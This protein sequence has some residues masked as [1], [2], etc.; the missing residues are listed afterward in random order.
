MS[1]LGVLMSKKAK[2]MD[3]YIGPF[4]KQIELA[5]EALKE[6][7]VRKDELARL[8]WENGGWKLGRGSKR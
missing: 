1:T 6:A 5:K 4:A 3:E 7:Q 2:A 8:A